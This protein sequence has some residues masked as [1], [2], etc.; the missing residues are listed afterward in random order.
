MADKSLIGHVTA[1]GSVEVEKGKLRF[2]AKAIGE[3][4]PVYTDPAAARD[5]GHRD[6]PVPPTF[7]FCLEMEGPNAAAMRELDTDPAN[8]RWQQWIGRHVDHFVNA[9]AGPEGMVLP[10]V[11]S[12][13]AQRDAK[14]LAQRDA[15]TA[16]D[17]LE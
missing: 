16:S 1:Q 3:T 10:A 8:R 5:A 15:A 2:F 14:P 4:D 11:W 9:G 7:L 13:A 6:L 17:P 12:L